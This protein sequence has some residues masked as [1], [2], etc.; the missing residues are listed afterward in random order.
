MDVLPAPSPDAPT[1]PRWRALTRR[2]FTFP[3]VLFLVSRVGYLGV[4]WMGLSLFPR[5]FMHEDGRQTFLQPYPAVDGLCRWDCAWFVKVL[6][7]G[8]ATNVHAAV[9]PLFPATGWLLEQIGVHHLITFIVLANV[10]ALVSYLLLY[11]LFTELEGEEVARWGLLLFAAYPFAYYQAAGY[12]ESALVA[13]TAG[14]LLLAQRKHYLWAGVVLGFGVMAR[15]LAL[16]GG[17]GL[18]F[19]YVRDRGFSP[20]R[21]FLYPGVLGLLIPWGFV[22]AFSYYLSV[23]LGDPFAFV[24]GRAIHTH[25]T[26]MGVR[27]ILTDITFLD[28]PEFTFYAMFV[29]IPTIGTIALLSRRTWWAFASIAVAMMAVNLWM[30]GMALGR[31]SATCW[32]AYLPLGVWAARNPTWQGPVLAALM[33]FQ[34]LFFFLFSHQ[35]RIL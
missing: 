23:K 28:R 35:F 30:G 31:Y 24:Q 11:Q 21:F 29:T 3:V 27:Q 9:C 13:S 25:L 7:E 17:A 2:V 12:A 22:A 26:W 4:S 8:Y 6:Q 34:G 1:V 16:L 18:L 14:T 19:A 5:L 10:L 33:L 15:Q 32:P 20:K